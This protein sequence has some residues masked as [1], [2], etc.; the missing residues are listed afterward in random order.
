MLNTRTLLLST[1]ALSVSLGACSTRLGKPF[2]DTQ[3]AASPQ[4]K[5]I[6][7]T[8]RRKPAKKTST[9]AKTGYLPHLNDADTARLY[10]E[11]F[12][13]YVSEIVKGQ[14][15]VYKNGK[16]S[17]KPL[18]TLR[19][20]VFRKAILATER[21]KKLT[22]CQF[23][24]VQVEIDGRKQTSDWVVTTKGKGKCDG[25]GGDPRYFW[26]IQQ[27]K[28]AAAEILLAG[29]ADSVSVI[30]RPKKS[31]IN[32][33]S[34]SNSGHIKIKNG[35]KLADGSWVQVNSSDNG[36]VEISCENDFRLEGKRY[37]SYKGTVQASVNSAMIHGKSWQP[38]DD[39]R[40]RCPF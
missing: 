39:P 10:Q 26:I 37:Q 4:K 33:I 35:D 15:S 5:S 16:F 24:G 21:G 40:Y 3:V 18:K 28:T 32:E 27:D 19:S 22:S 38:V 29:R 20:P 25:G 1:L 9:G 30:R 23:V 13:A 7:K 12:S 14:K 34:V 6:K 17:E 36:M 8:A 2:K 31:P 11:Y